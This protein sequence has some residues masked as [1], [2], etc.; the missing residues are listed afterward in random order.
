LAPQTYS[1]SPGDGSAGALVKAASEMWWQQHREDV[2]HG[3]TSLDITEEG[4]LA[5]IVQKEAKVDSDRPIIAGVFKNRLSMGMPLQSCATVVF[6]WKL[7]GVKVTD[8][9]FDDVKIDS[10]FNT[11]IHK[12]LPPENIGIPSE[13]S[14]SAVLKPASTDMLFFVAK[15]DGSHV[16]TRTYEEHLAAQRK[17]RRGDL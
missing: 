16:F 3:I 13:N 7:R 1:I 10:P 6:A 4:I 9:S 17:I 2:P 11:Y 5:S 8:V 14:W 15:H 12:G